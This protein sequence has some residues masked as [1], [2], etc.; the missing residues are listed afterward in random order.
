MSHDLH[1]VFDLADRIAVMKSGRLVATRRTRDV[2]KGDVLA[3]ILLGEL[4]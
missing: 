3:M 1:D 4:P 2:T